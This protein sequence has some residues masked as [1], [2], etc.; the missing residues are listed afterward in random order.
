VPVKSAVKAKSRLRVDPALRRA[1]ARAMAIDTISAVASAEPVGRTVVVV[2]D[3]HDG[4]PLAVLPGVRIVLT[5]TRELNAAILDALAQVP[6]PTGPVAV[7]PAD[8]PS[9]TGAELAGALSMAAGHRCSVVPD[10]AGTGTTMLAA[11]P[12]ALL[13][14]QFGEGS[15]RRHVA[16]GAVPLP[17]PTR[18]GLRRDVDL[19]ADLYSATG[20]ATTAVLADI[21]PSTARMT[22]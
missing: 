13:R 11:H 5:R 8:L 12:A 18:C 1:L 2:E 4:A 22:G 3:V 14:P 19:I 10:R 21:G 7:V 15:F 9:L 16:G 17:V 6:D 20:P